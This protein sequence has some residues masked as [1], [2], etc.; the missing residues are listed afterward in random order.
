MSVSISLRI[1]TYAPHLIQGTSLVDA[2][3]QGIKRLGMYQMG[4]GN[5][6]GYSLVSVELSAAKDGRRNLTIVSQPA[7]TLVQQRAGKREPEKT[8]VFTIVHGPELNHEPGYKW[9]TTSSTMTAE[10]VPA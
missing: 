4:L 7:Q 3:E 2:I 8:R 6:A 5:A 10:P 1:P 9:T